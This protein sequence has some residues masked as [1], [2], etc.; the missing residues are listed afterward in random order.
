MHLI[1]TSPLFRL[2]K[3]L[4]SLHQSSQNAFL[5]A[6]GRQNAFPRCTW[7]ANS[8]FVNQLTLKICPNY[9]FK[10]IFHRFVMLRTS[11]F[12][13]PS[14][15][16]Q[17]FSILQ[18]IASKTLPKLKNTIQRGPKCLQNAS[19]T[20]SRGS[21]D[22]PKTLPRR[23]KSLPR[24]SQELP[25]GSQEASWGSQDAPRH[26]KTLPRGSQD[27]PRGSQESRLALQAHF[28]IDFWLSGP[29][30]LQYPPMKFKV[31]QYCS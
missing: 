22:P 6:F 18:L 24:G 9:P 19:K 31:F 26:P 12:A 2:P 8:D 13:L 7:T 3:A 21:Q 11:I 10:L 5:I 4:W 29:R 15:E 16:F 30:F 23:P 14:N 1:S 25:R 28:F 27:A 17:G 20:L